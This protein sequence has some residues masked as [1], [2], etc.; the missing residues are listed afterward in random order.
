[1]SLFRR[2]GEDSSSSEDSSDNQEAD[3]LGNT[4]GSTGNPNLTRVNTIDSTGSGQTIPLPSRPT[5]T[6][7]NSHVRDLVLHALLEEKALNE[8]AEQL[9]KPKTDPE[10]QELARS[11]Y[12]A[13]ARQLSGPLDEQYASESMRAHRAAAQEGLDAV[14][15]SHLLTIKAVESG[16]SSGAVVPRGAPLRSLSVLNSSFSALPPLIDFPL[17]GYPGLHTDR[18]AQEFVELNV[19]GK[20]GYGKVYK[21]RHKLDNSFYAVKRIMVSPARLQKI[22][23]NGAQEM[24]T[25]LEEVRAL[26]KFD[27]GNIVR[28]HNCWLEY[29]S[30]ATDVPLSSAVLA[31]NSRLLG[32]ASGEMP[33]LDT[34]FKDLSFGDPFAKVE[35]FPDIV[36]E[37]SEDA[38]AGAQESTDGDDGSSNHKEPPKR[39]KRRGSHASQ[40]T[41]G[42]V[43]SSKT[44]MSTIESANGEDEDDIETIERAHQPQYLADSTEFSQSML[45]HSDMPN[46]LASARV[47]GP[48]LTLNVQMS[49]YDTSL[50]TY[51]SAEALPLPSASAPSDVPLLKHCFHPSISLE[52]LV[53]ILSGVEYLHSQGVVHRDLKPAN[54]FLSLSASRVPPSGSID[55]STCL[56]CPKR[57][58]LHITPRIGDFGLVAALGNEVLAH[59]S[60]GHIPGGPA[61]PVGTE[62]YRPEGG[63]R[64]ISEKL[65][66]FALGVVLFEMLCGFETR[67]ERY[68]ALGRLRRGEFP[69]GFVERIGSDGVGLQIQELIKSM[70][71]ADETKRWSCEEV[72]MA[73]V[74]ILEALQ[75]AD[76]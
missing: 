11:T 36:F 22:Q 37:A 65:D 61:K 5:V 12:Q 53:H 2:P 75:E 18:Y 27:H 63:D 47:S 68:D 23:E 48:V 66:V 28:Y 64:H 55:L 69:N 31:G 14:T 57:E 67:M 17:Q 76:K 30:M 38:G 41:V 54:I 44:H 34:G 72:R 59:P 56:H 10:V 42:T 9:G 71:N 70:V 52:L 1:M 4:N 62:F 20:G 58:F 13:L 49:L 51:L 15:R 60:D 74:R 19:V 39:R 6:R 46:Q 16:P 24:E 32:E 35:D 33:A 50:D 25:M 8:A 45:S 43:S 21:V 3:S 73:V 7:N 40:A 29:T 26:A